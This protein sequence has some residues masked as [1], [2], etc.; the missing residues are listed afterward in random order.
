MFE[1]LSYMKTV[2][3]MKGSKGKVKRESKYDESWKI[4]RNRALHVQSREENEFR[5][6][7]LEPEVHK[8]RWEQRYEDHVMESMMREIYE[9][10][11]LESMY[12]LGPG[13]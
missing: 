8:S 13:W 2:N 11:K 12:P 4:K 5:E 7:I 9:Q 1:E 3:V 6:E 10:R